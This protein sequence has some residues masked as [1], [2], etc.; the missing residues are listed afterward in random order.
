M[1]KLVNELWL[2]LLLVGLAGCVTDNSYPGDERHPEQA[3]ASGDSRKDAQNTTSSP[4]PTTT[5]VWNSTL[6][7]TDCSGLYSRIHL[8]SDF[9]GATPPN[10]W[11]PGPTPLTEVWVNIHKCV[12]MAFDGFERGPVAVLIEV[13]GNRNPP[14]SCRG[15]YV[16]SEIVTQ[17]WVDDADLAEHFSKE[18]SLPVR[19]AEIN[20]T[21]DTSEGLES[22]TAAFTP[23]GGKTSILREVRHQDQFPTSGPLTYRR[24]WTNQFGGI[25]YM[26]FTDDAT[27][28]S[29][30]PPIVSGE[31]HEPFLY[32]NTGAPAFVGLGGFYQG[33]S[34]SAPIKQFRDLTCTDPLP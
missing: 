13:H 29:T 1:S 26:D 30:T 4:E 2:L 24:F 23:D 7:M 27:T 6:F 19:H 11:G 14:Q 5:A 31:L 10:T 33:G 17:F 16:T 25:S 9:V 28:P 8:P 32:S 3:M 21:F 22:Y 34:I 15:D 12:R 20:L 18:Y